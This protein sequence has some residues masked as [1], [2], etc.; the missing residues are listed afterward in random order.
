MYLLLIISI[1]IIHMCWTTVWIL[2]LISATWVQHELDKVKEI[3][4]I[5]ISSECMWIM[6]RSADLKKIYT[7]FE[8]VCM[9]LET[10]HCIIL[11]I[12]NLTK[13]IYM[14]YIFFSYIGSFEIGFEGFKCNAVL[15]S[16]GMVFKL[17]MSC[18]LCA[19]DCG[20]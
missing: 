18:V 19:W 2:V 4:L 6:Q 11:T 8:N 3:K 14:V 1:N 12:T 10:S 7:H 13:I 15:C 17:N 20:H 16:V 5:C 9:T